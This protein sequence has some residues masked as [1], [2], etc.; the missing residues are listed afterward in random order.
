MDQLE[1]SKLTRFQFRAKQFTTYVSSQVSK[2]RDTEGHTHITQSTIEKA[3]DK[4]W[5]HVFR[6]RET[7]NEAKN[8]IF[9][10]LQKKLSDQQHIIIN[11]QLTIEELVKAINESPLLKSPGTDGIPLE[12]YVKIATN[13]RLFNSNNS[14]E[15]IDSN[16]IKF[17][18]KT[19]LQCYDNRIL[20]PSMRQIQIRFLFKKQT[21]TS[22]SL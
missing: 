11:Q 15:M 16:I 2:V 17:M 5:S 1:G 4:A 18:H 7:D 12:F 9:N 10:N 13:E 6:R 8:K 14:Q 3:W 20:T 22:I 19:F 21:G